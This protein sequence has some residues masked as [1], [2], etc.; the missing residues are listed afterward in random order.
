MADP[1]IPEG[2]T[3]GDLQFDQ[4]E[5]AG[6]APA[7]PTCAACRRPIPDAY[8]TVNGVVLCGACRARVEA[9]PTAGARLARFLRAGAFG[10]GAAI[11]GFAI[12]YGVAKV[13]GFE[14]SLISILV[15]FMVGGGRPQ[16]LGDAR[17]VGLSGPRHLP[18]LLGDRRELFHDDRP[19]TDQD[20]A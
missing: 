10:L 14:L 15:G 19:R 17:G 1:E 2:A 16:G 9:R 5:Y 7:A 4:A 18:D 12:Y 13:T 3:E 8:F 11:A 20:V 6:P